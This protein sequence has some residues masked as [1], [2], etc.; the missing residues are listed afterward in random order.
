ML[1][2]MDFPTRT[3][4]GDKGLAGGSKSDPEVTALYGA[5]PVV[6]VK[7]VSDESVTPA[8]AV[9]ANTQLNT[10]SVTNNKAIL[11]LIFPNM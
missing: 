1:Y 4:P 8:H 9:P 6:I 3:S 2:T 5:G 10:K 11:F 7:P